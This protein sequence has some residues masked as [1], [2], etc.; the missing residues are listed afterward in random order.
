MLRRKIHEK[1]LH[2]QCIRDNQ[3]LIEGLDHH[4]SIQSLEDKYYLDCFH[5]QCEDLLFDTSNQ[6]NLKQKI[7]QDILQLVG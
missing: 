1:S 3:L 6:N 4:Q 2:L 7:H 5:L